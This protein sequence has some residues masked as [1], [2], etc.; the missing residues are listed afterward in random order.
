MFKPQCDEIGVQLF[1]V[2]IAQPVERVAR[3]GRRTIAKLHERI[4]CSRHPRNSVVGDVVLLQFVITDGEACRFAKAEGQRWR[5]TPAIKLNNVA[6]G[7]TGVMGQ[8]VHSKTNCV[9]KREIYVCCSAAGAIS[10]EVER[11]A[12]HSS[13][14]GSLVKYVNG[15]A[16]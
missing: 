15:A 1:K 14:R 16:S 10:T 7:D 2:A 11:T 4:V 9:C 12:Q 3:D 8:Q 13:K 6:T 5:D